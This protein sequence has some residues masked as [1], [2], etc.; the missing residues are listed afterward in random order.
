MNFL[1]KEWEI[2]RT[3][4]GLDNLMQDSDVYKPQPF[5]LLTILEKC[6]TDLLAEIK[7]RP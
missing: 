4:D 6:L 2:F 3:S 5:T 1:S 7:K